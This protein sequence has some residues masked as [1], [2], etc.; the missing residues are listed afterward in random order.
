MNGTGVGP[1]S[2]PRH[3]YGYQDD[4]AALVQWEPSAPSGTPITGYTV[5][6]TPGGQTA[7]VPG[8]R[9]SWFLRGLTNDIEH[10]FSVIAHSASGDSPPGTSVFG[11]IP[12]AEEDEEDD[13]DAAWY[14]DND[15]PGIRRRLRE[16]VGE[17]RWGIHLTDVPA[18]RLT[19]RVKGLGP[20]EREDLLAA[21]GPQRDVVSIEATSTSLLDLDRA[22]E[23]IRDIARAM[24][25]PAGSVSTERDPESQSIIVTTWGGDG[26]LEAALRAAVP[27]DL[28]T[29]TSAPPGH[30]RLR[31]RAEADD[32]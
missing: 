25:R 18:R 6:A 4:G 32:G 13:P 10:H 23:M 7:A 2:A 22:I 17:H 14:E 1:P 15:I 8:D 3:V 11:T 21:L 30:M 31:Y 28:V 16:I 29:Y 27:D 5:T 24:P 20:A 26:S 19:I 9:S 12:S